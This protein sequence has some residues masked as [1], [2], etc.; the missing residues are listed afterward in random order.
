MSQAPE[1]N[2]KQNCTEKNSHYETLNVAPDASQEQIRQAYQALALKYHPDKNPLESDQF[3]RIN[4]A[5]KVLQDRESRRIYDA[6]RMLDSCREDY[7]INETLKRRDF[8]LDVVED[9]RWY[10]CR[11]G[12]RYLLPEELAPAET[13]YIACD[14][15]SLVVQVDP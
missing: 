4:E 10:G 12:G 13:C 6:E 15:C 11:C 9:A 14:E 2:S 3:F 8:Q 7:F 5:W 1:S